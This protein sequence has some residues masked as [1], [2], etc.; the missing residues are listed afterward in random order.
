MNKS[1]RHKVTERKTKNKSYIKRLENLEK[2][3][4][5][6]MSK[7]MVYKNTYELVFGFSYSKKNK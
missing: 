6:L 5:E 2:E 3:E 7:G 1:N 4:Q